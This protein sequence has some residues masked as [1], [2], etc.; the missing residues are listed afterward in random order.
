VAVLAQDLRP[1]D[2]VPQNAVAGWKWD[3]TVAGPVTPYEGG[4]VWDVHGPRVTFLGVARG[5][6][7]DGGG[8][9]VRIILAT[10]LAVRVM[11]E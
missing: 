4:D 9:L 2:L 11:R 1:G 7:L 6:D 8:R 5:P 3:V 10:D